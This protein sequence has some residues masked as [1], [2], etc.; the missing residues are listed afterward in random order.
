MFLSIAKSNTQN[1]R[2][3]IE[4]K[5]A[6]SKGRLYFYDNAKF[7]LIFLVVLGHTI[8]PFSEGG[9]GS[10]FFL[11]LWRMINVLHMPCMIFISGFF[12]KSYIRRDGTINVQRPF[13]YA[14]YYVA[15]QLFFMVFDAVVLD[16]SVAKTLLDPR[17][18][19]WFLVCL[20]WWHLL[21]PVINRI[22]P[23]WMMI[24]AVAAGI[25][26]GYD[27]KVGNFV[28]L[29]R[30]VVHF[31]FFLFGYYVS[32]DNMKFLTA[33][34]AKIISIPLTLG[35]SAV[36]ALSIFLKEIAG[37]INFSI[38]KFITC[39]VDYFEIFEDTGVS[40]L[41]WAVP[42]VC[43]YL[44]AVALSFSFLVWAPRKKNIF[45][46]FG[47]RTLAVYIL[48][49]CIYQA[50]RKFE[51]CDL[52]WLPGDNVFVLRLFMIVVAFLI[53]LVLSLYPFY[54]PFELL[55]KIKITGLIKK[56]VTESDK[57]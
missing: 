28:S 31:P 15:A 27:E 10:L 51:W 23:K 33:K 9:E 50:Y 24:I 43:F 39:N 48:H 11:F 17:S 13:T 25:L 32:S 22:N 29:S 55:G 6:D 53:T 49:R 57:K 3:I 12:A 46:R 40:P 56:T 34:K 42:R 54:I 52:E 1:P 20:I 35:A 41:L 21:L 8:S 44:C 7:I 45:T 18:S 47:A 37:V 14:M 4:N 36:V 26:I 19:L 5:Y 30:M 2:D 38:N 16:K